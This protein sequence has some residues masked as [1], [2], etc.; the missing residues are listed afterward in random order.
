MKE[1][2]D[3]LKTMQAL[4]DPETGCPWDIKQTHES[5]A[6]HTIEEA[7][8]VQ[9][10]IEKGDV[11]EI[12][13]ELGDLLLQVVFQA[14]IATEDNNFTFADIAQTLNDKLIRRH[15]HVFGEQS[16]ETEE[17]VKTLWEANKVK[18]R[19]NKGQESA[20]AGVATTLPALIRAQKLQ[21]RAAKVG[22]QWATSDQA[23]AKVLEEVKEIESA[24]QDQL[25]EEF[26]DL[27]LASVAWANIHKIDAEQALRKANAKFQKRFELM[28]ALANESLNEL[29]LDSLKTLWQKAKMS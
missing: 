8:E 20:L 27:L 2:E 18:E 24:K 10:A 11:Q 21:K 23:K 3:S 25:E 16:A 19:S 29:D 12:K 9:E 28:E 22:F 6:P 17:D 5:I 7:Y 1:I 26:G 14:Q 13:E 4:R 15:P